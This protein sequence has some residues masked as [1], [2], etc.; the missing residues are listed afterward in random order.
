MKYQHRFTVRAS[1]ER[2]A[3]F[4]AQSGSMR[5]ITPPPVYVQLHA[6]PAELA[7]GDDMDF[8][9]WFGPLP[10]RWKARIEQVS[11]TGFVDRQI[12]GP[13]DTWVHQ[14]RFIPID[15]INTEVRDEIELTL[16]RN[17]IWALFGIAMRI[18]LP[19]LFAYRSWRTRRILERN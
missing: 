19:V 2:V 9:L 17:P 10:V 15:Q 11:P 18:N 14:H 4:H 1:L 3:W 13:F 6:A 12:E 7:E 8:S 16:R 5:A